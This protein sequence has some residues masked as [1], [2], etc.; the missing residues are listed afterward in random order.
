MD[1]LETIFERQKAFDD[2][3]VATRRLSHITREEWLQKETLAIM[4]E[5][6]ELINEV[7]Y[8]WWKNPKPIDERAV[9]EELIDIL[10]FWVS[11]CLK[12]D[13]SA[14]EVLRIYL[15]KNEENFN[16]QH[17]TSAKDGYATPPQS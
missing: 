14:Q 12:M 1:I 17:G 2:E 4:D 6:S 15:G 9:K 16:R 7:N 8:K 13:M 11:M 10:H 3:L 5:L